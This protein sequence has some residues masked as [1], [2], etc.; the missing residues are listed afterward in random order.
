MDYIEV[1]S[2]EETKQAILRL[3]SDSNLYRQMVENGRERAKEFTFEA[4]TKRWVAILE[5]PVREE[6]E[7]WFA[8][9][10]LRRAFYAKRMLGGIAMDRARFLVQSR[11]W[12]G[13]A[14]RVMGGR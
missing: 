5:G 1:R 9:P 6:A 14:K 8:S 12:K 4:I 3:K 10:E 11:G 13:A 2:L 7:R